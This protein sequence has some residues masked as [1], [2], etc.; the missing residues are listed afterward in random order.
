[1]I[2]KVDAVKSNVPDLSPGQEDCIVVMGKT[3]ITLTVPLLTQ[4]C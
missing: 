3:L 1:M 4:A 2:S